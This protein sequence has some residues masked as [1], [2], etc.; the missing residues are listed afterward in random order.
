MYDLEKC[1]RFLETN[2]LGDLTED[3]LFLSAKL[4]KYFAV[5]LKTFN[6]DLSLNLLPENG[7]KHS[8]RIKVLKGKRVVCVVYRDNS[9]VIF[10]NCNLN[11]KET[12]I[13]KPFLECLFNKCYDTLIDWSRDSNRIDPVFLLLPI[14]TRYIDYGCDSKICKVKTN[15]K[16]NNYQKDLGEIVSILKKNKEKLCVQ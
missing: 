3:L 6:L 9:K 4:P 7:L 8:F 13:I 2:K 11:T 5:P 15:S 10:K 14:M 12:K 16:Y 1:L